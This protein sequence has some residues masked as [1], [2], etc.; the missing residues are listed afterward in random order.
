MN[1]KVLERIVAFNHE[2]GLITTTALTRLT[3]NQIKKLARLIPTG[4]QPSYNLQV[5]DE[6]MG[7]RETPEVETTETAVDTAE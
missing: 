4:W 7:R 3:S 6:V 5:W 2:K 1:R